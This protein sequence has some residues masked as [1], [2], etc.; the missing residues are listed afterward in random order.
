MSKQTIGIGSSANDG[1][2]DPL[3]TAFNKINSNFTE[4]YNYKVAS[5]AALEALS[6]S[7]GMSVLLT[8]EYDHGVF[9]FS[10]A[11]LSDEVT[12][13]PDQGLYIAPSSDDTGTSG[14]WV[15][16]VECNQYDL[17][18]WLRGAT[19]LVE[20]AIN[21]ALKLISY[22]D[23]L[24]P[25]RTM[26]ITRAAL[27]TVNAGSSSFY[28][29]ITGGIYIDNPGIR[30]VGKGYGSYFNCEGRAMNAIMVRASHCRVERLRA[31][32]C[33]GQLETSESAGVCFQPSNF[34]HS[35]TGTGNGADITDCV[36]SDCYFPDCD[37]GVTGSPEREFKTSEPPYYLYFSSNLHVINCHITGNRRQ[38]V[39]LF[40]CNDSIVSHCHFTGADK[41]VYTYSRFVR[42]IGSRN[43]HVVD[44]VHAEGFSDASTGYIGVE[45]STAAW[46]GLPEHY[47]MSADVFI[48]RNQFYGFGRHVQIEDSQGV[49]T[50]LENIFTNEHGTNAIQTIS[51]NSQGIRN[52]VGDDES[53]TNKNYI[54]NIRIFGNICKGQ[55]IF[56]QIPGTILLGKIAHNHFISNEATTVHFVN[57]D[58]PVTHPLERIEQLKIE[59]NIIITNPAVTTPPIN[60]AG[61]KAGNEIFVDDN[62]ITPNNSGGVIA[63][64]G[65]GI[66]SARDPYSNISKSGSLWSNS[67]DPPRGPIIGEPNV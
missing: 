6:A 65:L 32:N 23:V 31:G 16:R 28:N 48:A 43:V 9:V 15:R 63:H 2:G 5:I 64:T 13:D 49:V 59:N 8:S 11:D 61:L 56:A 54:E 21:R 35:N 27:G 51:L 36:V 1:T 50:I 26:T 3:R 10:N 25:N 44:T 66:V 62:E 42:V 60:V 67:F 14:A 12:A 4:V 45:V 18:W 34:V 47:E 37:S 30:L 41:G 33:S 19:T 46:Y 57:I 17:D 20:A 55:A 39:E 24:V 52:P 22:A 53:S 29:G 7:N 38:G 40:Y 58:L